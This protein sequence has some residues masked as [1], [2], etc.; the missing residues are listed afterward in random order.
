MSAARTASRTA[1]NVAVIFM[2]QVSKN[3]LAGTFPA[4][5]A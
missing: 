1:L 4:A 2:G 5:S 3:V